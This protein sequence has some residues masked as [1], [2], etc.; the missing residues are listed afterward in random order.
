VSAVQ[1]VVTFGRVSMSVNSEGLSV[2]RVH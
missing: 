1:A 2:A